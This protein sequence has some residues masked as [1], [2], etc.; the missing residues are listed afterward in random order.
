MGVRKKYI[1]Y[2][3]IHPSIIS[4]GCLRIAYNV[5]SLEP[6]SGLVFLYD[7]HSFTFES[8]EITLKCFILYISL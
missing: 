8:F 4:R 7:L 1:V 5:K 6:I 2:I 3:Y